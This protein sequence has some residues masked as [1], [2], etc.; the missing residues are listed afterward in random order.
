MRG[1]HGKADA[2]SQDTVQAFIQRYVA[3]FA[4]A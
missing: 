3:L 4:A 2:R 1:T